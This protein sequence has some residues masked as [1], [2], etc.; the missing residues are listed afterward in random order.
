MSDLELASIST[1]PHLENKFWNRYLDSLLVWN[2]IQLVAD[3]LAVVI[4]RHTAYCPVL[5]HNAISL[6]QDPRRWCPA[7]RR[8]AGAAAG[9]CRAWPI[10]D[11]DEDNGP[12]EELSMDGSTCSLIRNPRLRNFDLAQAANCASN[13]RRSEWFGSSL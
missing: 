9:P 4:G 2:I 3:N 13:R 7:K 10:N 11:V 1:P 5:F 6:R 12:V 8:Y